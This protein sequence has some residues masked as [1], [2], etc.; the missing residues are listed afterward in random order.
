MSSE[1][2]INMIKR[3]IILLIS[4]FLFTSSA[5]GMELTASWYSVDSLKRE[6]T[7]AY[8]K[9]IMANGKKFDDNA[10]TCATRLYPLG[11]ALKIT[12]IENN[13]FV[14]VIVTDRIS[15]RYGDTR[16]DLTSTAFR[17]LASLDSGLIK[18]NVEEIK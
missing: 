1:G 8:S 17:L 3:F 16:I 2:C 4:V 5:T 13:K 6:G 11:T 10:L 15:K 12:N 7:W 18:V 14:Y 9:G